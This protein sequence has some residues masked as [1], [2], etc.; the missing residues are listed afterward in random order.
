M[1][2]L[3][4]LLCLLTAH[5]GVRSQVQLQ[6]SG[7]GMVKPSQTLSLTCTVSGFS[8]TTSSYGWIWIRQSPAKGLEYIGYITGGGSTSY[9]P[10]LKS[11]ASISRDT[12]KNQ[13]SLQLSS[14][15]TEDSAVYYCAR[16][17]VR[18]SVWSQV[19]LQEPGPG[20]M[21][22][23]QTLSL[24][25][26]VSGFSITSSGYARSLISQP[27]GKELE[28]IKNINSGGSSYYSPSLKSHTSISRD[29]SKNHFSLQLSSSITCSPTTPRSSPEGTAPPQGLVLESPPPGGSGYP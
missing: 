18:G 27:P 12:S 20:M 29:T 2:L 6:E 24:I 4:L 9:S 13:F 25:F 3:G 22:P 7:P 16:D 1:R 26:I 15:S 5:Q 19:Q 14:L 28:W 10:S 17:T 8:I 11:R 21:Q 23:S